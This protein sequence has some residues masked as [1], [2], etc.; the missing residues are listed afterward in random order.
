MVCDGWPAAASPGDWNNFKR[1]WTNLK[2]FGPVQRGFGDFRIILDGLKGLAN[3]KAIWS[4]FGRRRR[5]A[6]GFGALM[7][8][9]PD[10]GDLV[11]I[12]AMSG[13]FGTFLGDSMGSGSIQS[14]L[15]KCCRSVEIL[16]RPR[17]SSLVPR[18]S[19]LVS[20]DFLARPRSFRL[21][22]SHVLARPRP[23]SLV[24][25][26]PLRISSLKESFG[27]EMPEI[28]LFQRF[29]VFQYPKSV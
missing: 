17:S 18:S 7:G 29:P 5:Q 9:G 20:S 27:Y 15:A 13:D 2:W 10:Q 8:L 3:F 22:S 11:E 28:H 24:P 26:S 6:E 21:S 25:P 16:A 14:N 1:I 4:N 23:S 12:W 19:S